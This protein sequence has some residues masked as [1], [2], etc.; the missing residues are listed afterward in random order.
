M[1]TFL[2][3]NKKKIYAD[4]VITI[5]LVVGY[6]FFALIL[7]IEGLMG[8]IVY[9]FT[10]LFA[11]GFLKVFS[12]LNKRNRGKDNN[13]LKIL[14]GLSY[15]IFSLWFLSFLFSMP[16]VTTQIIINLV[17]FPMTIVGISGIIKGIIIDIYSLRFRILNIIIGGFTIGICSLAYLSPIFLP[18]SFF[19][20]HIVALLLILLFNVLRRATPYLSEF[21]LS[22]LSLR[23][24][25]VFFYIISDYLLQVDNIGNLLLEKIESYK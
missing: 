17:A 22:I 25:K 2:N 19:L 3:I 10:A 16:N 1:S 20:F 23:N 11:E 9:P 24:L 12:S 7:R 14:V 15:M 5:F 21:G 6:L 8:I 13:F 18:R 4:N